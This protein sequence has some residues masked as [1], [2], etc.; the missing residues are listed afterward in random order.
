M[1]QFYV[2]YISAAKLKIKNMDEDV[3]RKVCPQ[4]VQM[5]SSHYQ[6]IWHNNQG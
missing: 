6:N 1:E 5:N 3:R 4:I 2:I